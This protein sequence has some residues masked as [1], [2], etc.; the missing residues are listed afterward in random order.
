MSEFGR[1]LPDMRVPPP[2]AESLALARRLEAVES[3][4]VTFLAPD[5]PVFWTEAGGANVRDADGNVY[6][7]LTGAF[8]V[9]LAGHAHPAVVERVREQAGRLVHGMGDV[10]PPE[11]KVELLE[12]LARLAPW[13]ECRGVLASSGSEAV[14]VALKTAELLTGR[15]RLI[16]FE[17][18]YHGLTL[19]SLAA[20]AR[21]AFREPFRGRIHPGVD[22]V[23]FPEARRPESADHSLECVRSFLEERAAEGDPVG[24]VIF[25]PI[26]GRAGVRIPPPGFLQALTRRARAAGAVV[27]ADEIFTGMGRTGHMWACEAEGVEPDI[28][29][30]GK[31]LGGG[32]PVSACLARRE[33]M[34][35]WPASGGEAIHTS[36]FLGH[37]LSCASAL[38]FLDVL[39][40]EGIVG[41]AERVGGVFL[42]ALQERLGPLEGVI[43]VRGRGLLIGIEV[44]QGRGAPV[45]AAALR[46]GVLTLPAGE[47]GEVVELAPPVVLTDA[48]MEA[49]IT[50]LAEAIVEA[51]VGG[52][53]GGRA[54]AEAS[55]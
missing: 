36:T 40:G 37:P 12:R 17:G 26:Q 42:A 25:E 24:A 6:I 10:H 19:G 11:L 41:Q 16:A 43:D 1:C 54:G 29:C 39:E 2:G 33:I 22:F 4:N 7:D 8:G 28:L 9:A 44:G 13:P 18:A 51:G 15:S 14:E 50:L 3:R 23:P 49:S 48:Q 34:D 27:I 20:T 47:R 32:L 21:P 5:F 31:A 30:A 35:A 52:G 45:T 55:P 53:H 38:A 46:R